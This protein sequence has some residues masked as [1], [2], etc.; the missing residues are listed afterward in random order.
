MTVSDLLMLGGIWVGAYPTYK[1]YDFMGL[2]YKIRKVNTEY[3]NSG[4]TITVP[5]TTRHNQTTTV[6]N[7]V[8]SFLDSRVSNV[9]GN[10]ITRNTHSG[11]DDETISIQ[12]TRTGA[13][14]VTTN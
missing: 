5:V 9:E 3:T 13:T 1:S 12:Y 11:I 6:V 2:E 10:N 7:T 4:A 8:P 14:I